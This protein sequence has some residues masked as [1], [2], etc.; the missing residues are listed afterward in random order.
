MTWH[1]Q[2]FMMKRLQLI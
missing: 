1:Y 2:L